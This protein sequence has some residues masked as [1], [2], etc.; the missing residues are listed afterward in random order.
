M[1]AYFGLLEVGRPE[2]SET[3]LVSG[4]AGGVGSIVGQ[5]AKIKGCRMVGAAGSAEKCERLTEASALMRP[6][7]TEKRIYRRPC[8]RPV[9]RGLMSSSTTWAAR[10]STWHW[11]IFASTPASCCAERF[12]VTTSHGFR[13]GRAN[14]MS[15][16]I[17]SARMEGFILM[18]YAA[19][20]PR[21]LKDLS[22]LGGRGADQ[23]GGGRGRGTGQRARGAHR[24]V[25]RRQS[26]QA[27]RARGP[28]VALAPAEGRLLSVPPNWHRSALL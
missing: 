1:S 2:E 12:R 7:I 15:L 10:S 16:I 24:P 13:P 22:T 4:A 23:V 25:Q 20:F 3:V 6:S 21:A 14:Y 26:G 19:Q 5:I 11:P 27:D 17:N 8:A 28:G 18:N 9:P